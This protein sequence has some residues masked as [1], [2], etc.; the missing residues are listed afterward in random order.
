MRAET[1]YSVSLE[2]SWLCSSTL[3]SA[4]G[5]MSDSHK[6]RGRRYAS[7]KK[8]K[9]LQPLGLSCLWWTSKDKRCPTGVDLCPPA[10]ELCVHFSLFRRWLMKSQTGWLS[11]TCPAT[12]VRLEWVLRT[13]WQ[14]P[15][16]QCNCTYLA[17]HLRGSL[18]GCG[19]IEQSD[20]ECRRE[21]SW[22]DIWPKTA[23]AK[24]SPSLTRLLTRDTFN[25]S[26]LIASLLLRPTNA[27]F[28][29]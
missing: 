28:L 17:S 27:A 24:L 9:I 5:M 19:L 12:S 14:H 6:L 15:C 23:I 10:C 11:G 22:A 18:R 16:F 1:S 26:A 21:R 29:L 4:T 2:A 25:Q 7:T 3:S 13:N 20:G 8:A